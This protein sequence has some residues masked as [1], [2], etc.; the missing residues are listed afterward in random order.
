[1][2]ANDDYYKI[3]QV[4]VL[5][6]PEVIESAYKRLAKKYHPDVCKLPGAAER[7]K[8]INEAYAT[9]SDITKRRE[10]DSQR[11]KKRQARLNTAYEKPPETENPVDCSPEAYE[12]L[13][14]YFGCLKQR[15]FINAYKLITEM[16]KSNITEDDFVRWQNSVSRIYSLQEYNLKAVKKE[17]PARLGDSVFPEAIEFSVETIEQNFVM[18]RL[19]RDTI[20]KKVVQD[21][22]AYRVYIGM[23]DVR[24]HIER[25]EALNNLLLVKSVVNDMAE[26]YS[27][28]DISTGLYNKKGFTEAAQRE[29]WRATRYGNV[30][31]VML[32]EVIPEKIQPKHACEELVRHTAEWAGRVLADNFRKLDIIGRWGESGFIILLP[33]TG[34]NSGIRAAKK[35]KRIFESSQLIFEGR[36]Y[37]FRL[38]LGVDEFSD[39]MEHLLENLKRFIAIAANQK[40]NAIV[41][42]RGIFE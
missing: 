14:E 38:N 40:K 10:Y 27:Y 17:A 22:S 15:E 1:M 32:C 21:G 26:Y 24:P 6:E 11:Q 28:K 12:V 31:S 37:K 19:E 16:D 29:I 34:L 41:L 13:K 35:A 2:P 3:L 36:E 5:A 4:H 8:K 39:S 23:G 18:G 30:F 20:Y 25:F 9:L 7:M 42:K 33:E